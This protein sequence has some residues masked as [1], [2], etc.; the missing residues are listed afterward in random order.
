MS[1]N[2]LEVKIYRILDRLTA[3]L[4][5]DQLKNLLAFSD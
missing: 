2:R 4:H 1:D 5:R 3:L